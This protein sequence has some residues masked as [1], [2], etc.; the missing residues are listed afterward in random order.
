M[1]LKGWIPRFEMGGDA[2]RGGAL[3][4]SSLAASETLWRAT[5]FE[6]HRHH[7]NVMSNMRRKG[8][9]V[10]RFCATHDGRHTP[11]HTGFPV[12]AMA[13][14]RGIQTTQRQAHLH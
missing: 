14:V 4:V 2:K 3:G 8:R 11:F 13:K 7:E 5:G 10:E 9:V 1:M 6:E 12:R